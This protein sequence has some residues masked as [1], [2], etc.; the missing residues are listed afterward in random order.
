M[1]GYKISEYSSSASSS[2]IKDDSALE[3]MKTATFCNCF[4]VGFNSVI[5]NA[6]YR[7]AQ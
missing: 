4:V 7:Q 2:S 1:L 6:E 5:C 3:S